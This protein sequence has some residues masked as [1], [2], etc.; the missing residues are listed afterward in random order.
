MIQLTP[1]QTHLPLLRLDAHVALAHAEEGD[2][3]RRRECGLDWQ[4]AVDEEGHAC[5]RL[6]IELVLGFCDAAL[7][8]IRSV[9]R[10]KG[11]GCT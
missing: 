5:R 8:L 4:A 7:S 9:G 10:W 3:D 1:R 2:H 11:G 6:S